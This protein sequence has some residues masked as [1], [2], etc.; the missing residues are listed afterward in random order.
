[1]KKLITLISLLLFMVLPSMAQTRTVSGTVR[2]SSGR[3]I[4]YATVTE[5]GK[6]NAVTADA[7]GNFSIKVTENARLVITAS[8]YQQMTADATATSFSLTRNNENL[9][10]VIVTAM[11]IRRSKNALP[12]AA[13]QISGDDVSQSRSNNFVSSMSGKVSGMEIRQGNGLGGATN[14]VIRGTK[15]L[16]NNNQALFVIDGVPVDNSNTTSDATA[17]GR[18]N[19]ANGRPAGSFDYGSAAA[20]INP[21]DIQSITVLKGAAASALYGSRATTGGKTG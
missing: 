11:G 4:P 15:S 5:M 10:E 1:M 18:V 17:T 21:D 9:S 20:D 7:D 14:V 13:Q 16:L 2:D 8:G 3:P 6:K 12:Y 19:D